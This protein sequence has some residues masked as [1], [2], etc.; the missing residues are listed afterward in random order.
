MDHDS[1]C[2]LVRVRRGKKRRARNTT[3]AIANAL[4]RPS[5]GHSCAANALDHTSTKAAKARQRTSMDRVL[6]T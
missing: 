2:S 1:I 3:I 6:R 4:K 5:T